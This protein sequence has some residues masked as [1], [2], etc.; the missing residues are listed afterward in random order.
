MTEYAHTFGTNL[1][2]W[3][4]IRCLSLFQVLISLDQQQEKLLSLKIEHR[5]DLNDLVKH[6]IDIDGLVG[7]DA[8]SGHIIVRCVASRF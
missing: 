6:V 7:I 3:M 8:F 1:G 5:R 2:M 4:C